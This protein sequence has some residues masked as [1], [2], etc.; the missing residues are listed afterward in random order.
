M[1]NYNPEIT[2]SLENATINKDMFSALCY[3]LAQVGTSAK[4]AGDA[5]RR[6][7]VQIYDPARQEFKYT[8]DVLEDL[9]R[10]WSEIGCTSFY[11]NPEETE[12]ALMRANAINMLQ[13]STG[14]DLLRAETP[15]TSEIQNEKTVFDFLEPKAVKLGINISD[16]M[17]DE[18]D[19]IT[20]LDNNE[21]L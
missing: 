4:E 17:D 8:V 10:K 6:L 19:C 5:L 3:N 7:S 16:L 12:E 2:F 11:L 14:V 18:I 20:P 21:F 1:I 9:A 15:G 13:R